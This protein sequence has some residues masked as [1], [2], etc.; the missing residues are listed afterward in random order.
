[1]SPSKRKSEF[2]VGDF[3][4]SALQHI[5]GLQ[6]RG[7]MLAL[8]SPSGAGKTTMTRKLLETDPDVQI[9]I[10]ATTRAPA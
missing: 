3:D 6:R 5:E 4:D 9:S 7:L 10:S 8:S 1:M 2:H